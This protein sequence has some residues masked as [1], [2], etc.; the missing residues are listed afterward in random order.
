VSETQLKV[1]EELPV[2]AP[3]KVPRAF[4]GADSAAPRGVQGG[5]YVGRVP[6]ESVVVFLIGMRINRW[7]KVRSWWPAFTGMPRMLAELE[8]HPEAGLLGAKNYWAGRSFLSVQYWRS[9]EHLGR[10]ARDPNLAHQPAWGRFHRRAA[11]TGDVGVWHETY[12]VPA[13][14]IESLYANMPPSGLGAALGTVARA[15]ARRT[16]A[17]DRMGQQDPA[18]EA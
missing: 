14:H 11:A 8:K 18:Y 15:V 17:Q 5:Q 1:A 6:E 7:R 9:A 2:E 10:Y 3:V 16:A 13:E 12:E 4:R